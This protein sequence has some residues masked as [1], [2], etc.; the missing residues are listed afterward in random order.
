MC[1]FTK[2]LLLHAS[3]NKPS[4]ITIKDNTLNHNTQKLT[5]SNESLQSLDRDRM[6]Q[7]VVDMML[8]IM[9]YVTGPLVQKQCQNL[10]KKSCHE[11]T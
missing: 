11:L 1:V 4:Q 6:G 3:T 10:D 8:R 9:T 2:S 7:L 5:N